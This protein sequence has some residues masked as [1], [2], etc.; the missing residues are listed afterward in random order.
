MLEF[1]QHFLLQLYESHTA[2]LLSC[3]HIDYALV[4]SEEILD[5]REGTLLIA[6]N[7]RHE[8]RKSEANAVPNG[9]K[10]LLIACKQILSV[11]GN[12][13]AHDFVACQLRHKKR[14]ALLL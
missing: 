8:M 4:A 3:H 10:A 2:R 12:I 9:Q 6:S 1:T 11:V 13:D 5:A 14:F 7:I